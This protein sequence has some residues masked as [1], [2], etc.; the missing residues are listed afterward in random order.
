MTG[1]LEPPSGNGGSPVSGA[2]S[3]TGG[4]ES[5]S[6]R[7]AVGVVSIP[8][9]AAVMHQACPEVVPATAVLVGNMLPTPPSALSLAGEATLR[10]IAQ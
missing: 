5:P 2:P 3:M 8:L 10:E 6:V 4:L 9:S 1:V 7:G